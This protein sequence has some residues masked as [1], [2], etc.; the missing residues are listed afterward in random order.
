M[1]AGGWPQVNPGKM[2]HSVTILQQQTVSDVSGTSI[3]WVA[4]L[5]T[6]AQIDPIRATD[7]VKWGQDT[8]KLFLIVTIRWQARIVPNMRI[9][10]ANGTYV[11]Q[12]IENPGERNVILVL[13]CLGLGANQ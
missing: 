1:A 5:T 3:Q 9:Q 10:A 7:V 2:V 13:T 6:W 8:A 4:F 11:I 12:A